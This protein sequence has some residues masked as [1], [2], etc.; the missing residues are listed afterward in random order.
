MLAA[1]KGQV[2]GAVAAGGSRRMEP[3]QC[4]EMKGARVC[5]AW[6]GGGWVPLR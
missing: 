2:G 1:V 5:S 3:P 4:R 6:T